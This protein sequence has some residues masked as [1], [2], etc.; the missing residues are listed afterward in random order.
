MNSK[1]PAVAI[2]LI[3][4]AEQLKW[5]VVVELQAVGAHSVLQSKL[6]VS[7]VSECMSK[8]K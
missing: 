3:I 7:Q 1:L 2:S 8:E 4:L 6:F 5:S